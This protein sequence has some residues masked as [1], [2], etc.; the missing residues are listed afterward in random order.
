MDGES[1]ARSSS[2][3]PYVATTDPHSLS[4][5]Q[6][7]YGTTVGVSQREAGKVHRTSLEEFQEMGR[8]QEIGRTGNSCSC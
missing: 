7:F 3:S 6:H 8:S 5:H 1:R 4:Q 2:Y